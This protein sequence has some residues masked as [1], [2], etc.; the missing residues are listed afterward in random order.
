MTSERKEVTLPSGM[1]VNM[2]GYGNLEHKEYIEALRSVGLTDAITRVLTHC[3]DEIMDR[4]RRMDELNPSK[5]D[6]VNIGPDKYV[7]LQRDNNTGTLAIG[8]EYNYKASCKVGVG[9]DGGPFYASLVG[10]DGDKTAHVRI[11]DKNDLSTSQELLLKPR[12]MGDSGYTDAT[13]GRSIQVHVLDN[14]YTS[15]PA[16]ASADIGIYSEAY[17]FTH[18]EKMAYGFGP[19]GKTLIPAEGN[20]RNYVFCWGGSDPKPEKY[21]NNGMFFTLVALDPSRLHNGQDILRAGEF[22]DGPSML[23]SGKLYNEGLSRMKTADISFKPGQGDMFTT[24]PINPIKNF[25]YIPI[26][27][28]NEKLFSLIYNGVSQG[29]YSSLRL[30]KT[31][32]GYE[33][34]YLTDLGSWQK[35]DMPEGITVGNMSVGK[36]PVLSGQASGDGGMIYFDLA[37]G[38]IAF[39]ANVRTDITKLNA[40]GTLKNFEYVRIPF[41]AGLYDLQ[42]GQPEYEPMGENAFRTGENLWVDKRGDVFTYADGGVTMKFVTNGPAVNPLTLQYEKRE[43]AKPTGVREEPLKE[44][45]KKDKLKISPNPASD[46]LRVQMPNA[47]RVRDIAIYDLNGHLVMTQKTGEKGDSRIDIHE[48]A[49]GTYNIMVEYTNAS[50]KIEFETV[51]FVKSR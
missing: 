26:E 19:D 29:S 42:M 1:A 8:Y 50:G 31:S 32:A 51:P 17:V 15:D 47:S 18:G 49:R 38:N 21:K 9:I 20:D 4:F 41:M 22:M 40:D 16:K 6:L 13:S 46:E 2:R 39:T 11:T 12:Q 45:A 43:V 7:V 36:F 33:L 5:R 14:V 10:V 35:T 27:A 34:Y 37:A 44:E 25:A 28:G 24:D 23:Q 30:C 48:L 3:A